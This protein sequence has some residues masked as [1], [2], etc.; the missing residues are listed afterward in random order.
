LQQAVLAAASVGDRE[1]VEALMPAYWRHL[2]TN[3][4]QIGRLGTPHLVRRYDPK[5]AQIFIEHHLAASPKL[6]TN[7]ISEILVALRGEDVERARALIAVYVDEYRE[8][9]DAL[10]E[11]VT[12]LNGAGHSVEVARVIAPRLEAKSGPESESVS[13]SESASESEPTLEGNSPSVDLLRHFAQ[14]NASIG[15]DEDAGRYLNA[16]VSR[17]TNPELEASTLSR[18]CTLAGHHQLGVELAERA[19]SEGGS[20]SQSYLARGLARLASGEGAADDF[21]RGLEGRQGNSQALADIAVVA[22]RAEQYQVAE[23]YLTRLIRLPEMSTS[24]YGHPLRTAIDAV[25]MAERER[26]GVAFFDRTIPELMQGTY[27]VDSFQW[28]ELIGGLL[29]DAGLRER[30][31]AWFARAIRFQRL[32]SD[33]TYKLNSL[34]DAR[35]FNLVVNGGDID[36]ALSLSKAALASSSEPRTSSLEIL[37]LAHKRRGDDQEARETF[38]QAIR[39]GHHFDGNDRIIDAYLQGVIDDGRNYTRSRGLERNILT[40]P[41]R[42]YQSHLY[43]SS[44]RGYGVG[45]GGRLRQRQYKTPPIKIY[46]GAP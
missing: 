11:L 36:S 17:A 3:D 33:S 38:R 30:A 28:T 23:T 34:L 16:I 25:R 35:A 13:G 14:A 21:A 19:F 41:P 27:L 6:I 1:S 10:V 31:D 37:A 7:R 5:I 26:W 46:R 45:H 20:L 42:V 18:S 15:R 2:G 9:N 24:S 39:G 40:L 43:N 4:R 44:H 12:E 22:L 32:D 8:R 29:I